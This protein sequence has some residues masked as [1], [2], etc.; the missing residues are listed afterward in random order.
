MQE[1]VIAVVFDLECDNAPFPLGV[2]ITTHEDI[3]IYQNHDGMI[4]SAPYDCVTWQNV[5][6]RW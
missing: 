3:V 1:K 4:K 6:V 5:C 2:Y